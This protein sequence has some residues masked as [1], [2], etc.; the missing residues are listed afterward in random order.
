MLGALLGASA[1]GFLRTF[2]YSV[3]TV[4][5][6]HS[7]HLQPG[8]E[9]PNR[10]VWSARDAKRRTTALRIKVKVKSSSSSTHSLTHTPYRVRPILCG[11]RQLPGDRL[12]RH[13]FN[14]SLK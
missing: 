1:R 13:C 5:P 6:K 14:D 7:C 4:L 3:R 12:S 8:V 11:D 10:R 2:T 9:Q